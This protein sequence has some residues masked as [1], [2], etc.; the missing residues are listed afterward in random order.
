MGTAQVTVVIPFYN[1]DRYIVDA[2][3]SVLNQTF[4]DWKLLLVNDGSTESYYPK[5]KIMENG[6]DHTHSNST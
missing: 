3:E 2:I 1:P 6:N 4:K 5:I